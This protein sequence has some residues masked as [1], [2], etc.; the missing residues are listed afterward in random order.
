MK[1]LSVIKSVIRIWV[2]FLLVSRGIRLLRD[3]QNNYRRC[4][5]KTEKKV[6]WIFLEGGV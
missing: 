4:V 2:N 5:L 1:L 3:L 6:L